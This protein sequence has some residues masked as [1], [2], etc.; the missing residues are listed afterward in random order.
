MVETAPGL[1]MTH[2]VRGV[3]NASFHNFAKGELL[4][5]I[6]WWLTQQGQRPLA[7]QK[8]GIFFRNKDY[9]YR[10]QDWF[11][12][13]FV[14]FDSLRPIN[15]L[16]VKKGQVF[17]GWTSIKLGLMCLTQRPQRSDACEAR[18]RSPSVSSQAHYHWTTALPN[19]DWSRIERF[20]NICLIL[21]ERDS[22][23]SFFKQNNNTR[24]FDRCMLKT[25]H[26]QLRSYGD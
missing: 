13:D 14:W 22:M 20:N 6:F 24:P 2:Y 1:R 5:N 25:Y 18:T 21:S 8:K 12:F 3:E 26:Q 10:N 19:Q 17:L 16:S 23:M 15:N 11:L 4:W 7:Y 9:Q